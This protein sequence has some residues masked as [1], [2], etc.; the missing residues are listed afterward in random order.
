MLV[1]YDPELPLQVTQSDCARPHQPQDKASSEGGR[2]HK[3]DL[4]DAKVLCA[5]ELEGPL[6]FR[7][8]LEERVRTHAV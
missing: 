8:Q 6:R 1:Q 5:K 2:R 7:C 4:M 3:L